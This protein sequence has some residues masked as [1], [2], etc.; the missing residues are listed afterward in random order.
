MYMSFDV[1]MTLGVWICLLGMLHVIFLPLFSHKMN[2]LSMTHQTVLMLGQFAVSIEAL[3]NMLRWYWCDGIQA[4]VLPGM[5]TMTVSL[6]YRLMGVYAYDLILLSRSKPYG[7][8]FLHRI[9]SMG[10]CL[11]NVLAPC[12]ND[13]LHTTAIVIMEYPSVFVHAWTTMEE[14]NDRSALVCFTVARSVFFACRMIGLGFL[15]L[16]YLV[17][18][19]SWA[20]NHT[21]MILS[22]VLIYMSSLRWL[23]RVSV[24]RPAVVSRC[25]V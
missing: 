5:S 2:P 18:H 10:V 16:V 21:M 22:L 24:S 14:F 13:M 11:L 6:E 12:G 3:R 4:W 7:V 1:A 25:R 17:F 20:W 8:A 9:M 15:C 19:A 23:H